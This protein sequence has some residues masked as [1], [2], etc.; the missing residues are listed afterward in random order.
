MFS[1]GDYFAMIGMAFALIMTLVIGGFILLF[2]IARRLGQ[3][4]EEW[5]RLRREESALSISADD[6]GRLASAVEALQGDVERLV[7]RQEFVESLLER[8]RGELA[9][10]ESRRV[11]AGQ[12]V[13]S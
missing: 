12:R 5:L 8:E 13:E 7:A 3:A 6:V 9:A 11:G 10:P 2:P 4:L 1:S